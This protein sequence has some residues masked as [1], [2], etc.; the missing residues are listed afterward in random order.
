MCILVVLKPMSVPLPRLIPSVSL[1]PTLCPGPP[2]QASRFLPSPPQPTTQQVERWSLGHCFGQA[3]PPGPLHDYPAQVLAP[4]PP[5][6]APRLSWDGLY[7]WLLPQLC[8]AS[9]LRLPCWCCSC[10]CVTAGAAWTPACGPRR[11]FPSPAGG[12]VRA[13][14]PAL[15]ATVASQRHRRAG[16]VPRGAQDAE[17]ALKPDD[18]A[19][20]RPAGARSAG[21]AAGPGAGGGWL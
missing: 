20:A 4:P 6:L 16:S 2:H 19:V 3:A 11:P 8:S 12:V 7:G 13:P 9:S 17:G 10:F 15:Q 5:P 14:C 18:V 21:R 1:Y